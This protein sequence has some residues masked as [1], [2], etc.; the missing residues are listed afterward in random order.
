MCFVFDMFY[1]E[2]MIGIFDLLPHD[3]VVALRALRDMGKNLLVPTHN[4]MQQYVERV[5]DDND[6]PCF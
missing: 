5:C 3:F 6:K 2:F 1:K 4:K